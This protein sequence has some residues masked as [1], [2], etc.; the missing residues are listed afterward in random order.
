M[1]DTGCNRR[2]DASKPEWIRL[3]LLLWRRDHRR[4]RPRCA[5]GLRV[6]RWSLVAHRLVVCNFPGGLDKTRL[7]EEKERR[8]KYRR[9]NLVR[10]DGGSGSGP[11]F[12]LR[13]TLGLPNKHPSIGI[14]NNTREI[15]RTFT[16]EF[17]ST[18]TPARPPLSTRPGCRQPAAGHM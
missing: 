13:S 2:R 1:G 4:S 15:H 11:T 6:G 12:R 8:G 16:L 10:R 17:I 3:L 5:K 9:R 7:G 18:N 14:G